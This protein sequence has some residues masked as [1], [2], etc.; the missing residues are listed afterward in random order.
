MP[1]IVITSELGIHDYND[2]I[3][4]DN[5]QPSL[6]TEGLHCNSYV[7]HPVAAFLSIEL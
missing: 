3:R 6:Y 7:L 5:R 1:L 2:I 4:D